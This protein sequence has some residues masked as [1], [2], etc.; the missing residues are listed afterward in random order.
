[1]IDI[2]KVI[3]HQ[4]FAI[5]KYSWYKDSELWSICSKCYISMFLYFLDSYTQ[6]SD[7]H[8]KDLFDHYIPLSYKSQSIVFQEN[9]KT[10]ASCKN[11][12][13]IKNMSLVFQ[14]KRL[15]NVCWT[16]HKIAYNK[17]GI[18]LNVK[19]TFGNTSKTIKAVT[20]HN[21]SIN[22]IPVRAHKNSNTFIFSISQEM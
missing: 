19:K 13:S 15:K 21:I 8:T 4:T 12:I 5:L 10:F 17:N 2:H 1:M 11:W 20:F 14:L 9:T 7:S 22:Y 16:T 18:K 6:K 3:R